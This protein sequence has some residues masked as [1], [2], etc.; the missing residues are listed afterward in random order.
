MPLGR[1]LSLLPL[2]VLAAGCFGGGEGDKSK[3]VAHVGHAAITHEQLDETVDHFKEEAQK[4]G[5][6]FPEEGSARYRTVERQ[7]LGLLVYRTELLRSAARL[8]APVT[9]EEV[10]RRAKAAGGEA[11]EEG[12]AFIESTIRSQIA[13]EHVYGKVTAGVPPNGRG[14]AMTRFLSKMKREY[15]GKVS[16]EPGLGPSS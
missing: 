10:E 6:P 9:D 8:G 4:E 5:K 13:Y 11:E 3:A 7:A 15:A 14:A 2:A 16:Y 12:G 1:A